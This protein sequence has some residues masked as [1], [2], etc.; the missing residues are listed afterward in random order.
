MYFSQMLVSGFNKEDRLRSNSHI[1]GIFRC[2]IICA[3]PPKSNRVVKL[4]RNSLFL[5]CTGKNEYNLSKVIIFIC[6]DIESPILQ[7]S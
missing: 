6:W 2:T 4:T 7:P 1:R 3:Y 5:S